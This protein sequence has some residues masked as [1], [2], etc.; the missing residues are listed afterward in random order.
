M[1]L[2]DQQEEFRMPGRAKEGQTAVPD[3]VLLSDRN[4]DQLP[5][6]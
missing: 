1:F 3:G 4:L 6:S 5:F 2:A